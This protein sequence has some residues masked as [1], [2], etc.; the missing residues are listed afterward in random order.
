MKINHKQRRLAAFTLAEMLI[1]SGAMSVLFLAV[2]MG[3]MA[4][5][6]SFEATEYHVRAQNDQARVFDYLGRD[7]HSATTAT[8]LDSGGRLDLSLPTNSSGSLAIHLELPILGSLLTSGTS[9]A[10]NKT[11]SYF[12]EGDRL[13]RSENGVQTEL[14]RAVSNFKV[15]RSGVRMVTEMTF[16]P[17]Y[18]QSTVV[19]AQHPA[20]LSS[21]VYLRNIGN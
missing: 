13:I 4:L 21:T 16:S 20:K 1:A 17:R 5:R 7:L 6:R 14:A 18:A 9:Q 10:T 3:S 19:A 8:V 2:I 11:I 15:T 12:V